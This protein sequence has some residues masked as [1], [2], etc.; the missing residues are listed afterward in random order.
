MF[1]E[2]YFFI[3]VLKFKRTYTID[4]NKGGKL[5]M[6]RTFI[7][8][9]NHSS[10]FWSEEQRN[11]AEQYGNIID[12]PFPAVDP[13]AEP[14]E[15]TAMADACMEKIRA[16]EE[17]TV[18]VQGEFT[19]VFAIVSRLKAEGIRALAA[20]SVR[21]VVETHSEDGT[22]IK[23]AVFRFRGFREYV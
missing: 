5:T 18:L 14:E 11:A 17:P 8:L 9:T 6:G 7:N 3:F 20:C 2:K 13:A 4:N 16:Y 12:I 22:V 1:N 15:I 10:G 19:L 23:R 21:Q